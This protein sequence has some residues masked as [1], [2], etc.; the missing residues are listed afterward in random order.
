M[1]YCAFTDNILNLCGDD[2]PL[3]GVGNI[4]IAPVRQL[5][6]A[7]TVVSA[8]THQITALGLLGGGFWSKIEGRVSTKDLATENAKDG[9]GSVFSITA[10]AVIPNLDAAK[11]FLLKKYGEQK[12]VAVIELF[13]KDAGT[14]NRKA[15]VVGFDDL[16][17]VSAGAT[18]AYN[19]TLEAE[20]GGVNGYNVVITA[21]QGESPRF[22]KGAIVVQDGSTGTTVNLG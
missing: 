1:S 16:M 13:T 9:G 22:Y 2:Y 6:P 11:S 10:N 7:V 3:S 5:D 17:G 21:T 4:Y 18:L 8:T 15:I 12:I 19:D 20:Q 14:G